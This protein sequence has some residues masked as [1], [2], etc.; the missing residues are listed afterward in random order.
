MQG[1]TACSCFRVF[2]SECSPRSGCYVPYLGMHRYDF[3]QTEFEQK[4]I[5]LQGVHPHCAEAR[6]G[7]QN[8]MSP[9]L[10]LKGEPTINRGHY[11]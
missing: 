9:V 1:I 11:K 2:T 3:K 8:C 10:P 6:S 5:V 7:K 4:L